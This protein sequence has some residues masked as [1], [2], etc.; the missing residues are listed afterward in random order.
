MLDVHLG[1]LAAYLR[2]LGLDAEYDNHATDPELVRRSSEGSRILLTRDRGL[3]KHRSVTRGY[4]G[5]QTDSRR[6]AV[7]IVRRFDLALTLDPF[8]RCMTCNYR[9]RPVTNAEVRDRLPPRVACLEDEFL[10]CPHCLRVYWR[11]S[12]YRRMERWIVEMRRRLQRPMSDR[13]TP[14]PIA[15]FLESPD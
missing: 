7:E 8:T 15:S 12:H 11:G 5:R 1:R 2:M 9:L 10:E 14:G 6:Q 3:L 13:R 4:W